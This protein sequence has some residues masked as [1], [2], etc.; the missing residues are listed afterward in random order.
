MISTYYMQKTEVQAGILGCRAGRSA[1]VLI[2]SARWH[3]WGRG[4][5]SAGVGP[6]Q[7]PDLLTQREWAL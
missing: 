1:W 7:D 4:L 5:S 2:C 6:G 3:A